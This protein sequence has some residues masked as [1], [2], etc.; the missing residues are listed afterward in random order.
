MQ[1]LLYAAAAG[2]HHLGVPPADAP[3]ASDQL[4]WFGLDA[5]TIKA[6]AP[7]VVL[8]RNNNGQNTETAINVNTASREVLAA[9][10]DL[11]LAT[12][13]T[14]VQAR[15]ATPSATTT[16][17]T[18]TCRRGRKAP[19]RCRRWPL[20]EQLLHR[21]RPP[22]PRKRVLEQRSLVYREQGAPPKVQ[23]LS[24]EWVNSSDPG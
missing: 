6:L 5:N 1:G 4:Q 12:A 17:T 20:A 14:L 8:I 11:N 2:Q 23:I 21:R 22:P 10:L 16:S 7:Y 3:A 19:R 18:S 15:R 13:E 24:S 9:V